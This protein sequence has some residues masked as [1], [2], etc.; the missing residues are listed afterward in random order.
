MLLETLGNSAD[1]D[2]L[3]QYV[4]CSVL[5]VN[6]A[7]GDIHDKPLEPTGNLLIMFVNSAA[8]N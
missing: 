7:G 2:Q 8:G 3:C 5:M 6:G 1:V 4:L